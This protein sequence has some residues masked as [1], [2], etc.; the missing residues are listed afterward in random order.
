MCSKLEWNKKGKASIISPSEHEHVFNKHPV[1]IKEL[2]SLS[3]VTLLCTVNH[4]YVYK[5]WFNKMAIVARPSTAS[6][7]E[8]VSIKD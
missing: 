6:D 2:A 3:Y 5:V 8:L 7:K 1:N 4:D